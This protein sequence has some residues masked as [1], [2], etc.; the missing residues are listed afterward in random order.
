MKKLRKIIAGLLCAVSVL[1][2][3][4]GTNFVSA[5]TSRHKT[6]HVKAHIRHIKGKIVWV[7]KHIRHI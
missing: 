2:G 7:R 3:L 6:V 5:K 1:S 4:G